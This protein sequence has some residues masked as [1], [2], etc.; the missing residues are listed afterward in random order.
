MHG[1]EQKIDQETTDNRNLGDE[2]E[3]WDGRDNES[4]RSGKFLFLTSAIGAIVIFDI[5]ICLAI[6]M[7][8]P[9]LAAWSSPLPSIAWVAAAIIVILT[10]VWL[11]Q[12]L[13]TAIMGKNFLTLRGRIN[14]LFDIAFSGAFRLAN[15]IGISRDRMGHSFVMVYNEISRATKMSRGNE[16]LLILLP[17]CLTK[18]QLAEINSL[19]EVYPLYIHIVSGGELARKKIAEIRPTAVIGVACE[20]DLVS[21]I[22]DVGRRISLIGIP[23]RR[24]EGPCKNTNVDMDE[25]IHAIEFYVGPPKGVAPQKAMSSLSH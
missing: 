13:L 9:R 4:I 7:I 14:P 25:L 6:Y 20:R 23:N 11:V 5:M 22:R 18:E 1:A 15:L 10:I 2:W 17:R 12:I 24:P 19:K 8:T 21:G 16:K 3:D